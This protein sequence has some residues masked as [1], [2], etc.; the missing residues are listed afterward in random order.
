MAVIKDFKKNVAAFK[1]L[2]SGSSTTFERLR[3]VSGALSGFNPRLD[4]VLK[5]YDKHIDILEHAL[6]GEVIQLSAKT[7]PE[8]TDEEKK[9]KAAILFF[10]KV[11]KDLEVEIDRVAQEIESSPQNQPMSLWKKIFGGAKGPLGLVTVIAVGAVLLHTTSATIEIKNEGCGALEPQVSIPIPLPG[12]S[13]PKEPIL[14]GSSGIAVVPQLPLSVD[15]SDSKNLV[16]SSLGLSITFSVGNADEIYFDD[17][18]L[19][20]KQSKIDLSSTGTHVL[21]LVCL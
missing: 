7:L 21:R 4:A 10:I 11:S 3:A 9:R 12:L 20:G 13:L 15:G 18:S 16:M 5:E 14:P 17:V 2:F 6:N 19:I 8:S 1:D